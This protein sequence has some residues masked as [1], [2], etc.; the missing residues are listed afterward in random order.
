MIAAVLLPVSAFA[1]EDESGLEKAILSA[2]A[3]FTIPEDY[4]FTYS[5]GTDNNKKIWYLNWS[6]KDE[7]RGNISVRIDESGAIL[8]YDKYKYYEYP[9]QKTLP[10]I[11]RQEAK[12]IADDFIKRISPDKWPKVRYQ[13]DNRNYLADYGYDFVYTRVENGI[14]FYGNSVNVRV[15]GDTGE[16][17]SYYVHWYD[18]VKF[19]AADGIISQEQAREAYKE[20]LGLR[21][22]YTYRMENEKPVPYAIY[23]PRYSNSSYAIDALTG[24]KIQIEGGYGIFY[25]GGVADQKM[26][27]AR[28]VGGTGPSLTPEELEAVRKASRLIDADEAEDIAR[29]S[30]ILEIDS[31]YRLQ[32]YN[33]TRS[34]PDSEEYVWS[35]SFNRETNKKTGEYAYVS[36]SMNAETGEIISF[37]R[38]APYKEGETPKYDLE[39][40][41][42][43]VEEFLKSFKPDKYRNTEYD[44]SSASYYIPYT[45]REL[46]GQYSFRYVRLV[47]G[48]AFPGNGFNA[49]FDAVN[50]R[51]SSFYMNW[52]DLDFPSVDNAVPLEEVY[53]KLYEEVGIELQYKVSNYGVYPYRLDADASRQ[54]TDAML[55]YCLAQGKPYTFDANTGVLL[56]SDGKPYKEAGTV[57]YSDIAGHFA[58]EQIKILAEYGIALEGASFSPDEDISQKDFFILLTKVLNNYYG[59]VLVPASS[60]EEIDGMY[61]YLVREGIVKEGEKSPDSTV[62]RENSVKFLIRA[63]KYDKVADIKGIF[64]ISF[65]DADRIN[66]D[67]IGYVA[68]AGG[69]KI[70]N[71][72]I[73]GFFNPVKKLT[74]AEA[75]VIIYNYLQR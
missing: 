2:K 48:V 52:Y 8:G 43:A 51:V 9:R 18:N 23:A 3:K 67:L 38:N 16:V 22:I 65:K 12:T 25:D 66:P 29:K 53:G 40:S 20:K 73:N 24:E 46:P 63:L 68:I 49:D 28:A 7:Y 60:S 59:P 71:G 1:S 64:N 33:L 27:L 30:S 61:D 21:L 56:G 58:E 54:D 15:D 50:G 45:E 19:P 75:A 34:W 55:V 42:A 6:S 37:Y 62:T 39:A 36:V 44:E 32:Y 4:S 47:N 74:R 72:D 13:E 31:S 41:R 69:L 11:S 17:L 26:E 5:V 14:P 10:K 70:V 57:E 35:L